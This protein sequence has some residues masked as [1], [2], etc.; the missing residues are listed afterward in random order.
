MSRWSELRWASELRSQWAG[1]RRLR[2]GLLAIGGILWIQGLLLLGDAA[3]GLRQQAV[4]LREDVE[5]LQP[6][7]RSKVWPGRAEDARQQVGALRSM[8]WPETDLGVAEAAAQ[9]WLRA[10]ASKS[11]LGI[12]NLAVSRPA[13][14]GTAASAAAPGAA[15]VQAVR[16][17]MTTEL[18]RTALTAFLAELARNE[19]VVIVDRLALRTASQPPVAEMDLRL[20]ASLRGE[21]K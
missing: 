20:L 4:S 3:V 15:N 17:R 16:L 12:R 14:S 21:A 18:N 6:L 8:L 1:N 7:A 5:R 13:A 10:L 19:Q 11:R 9:D 2:W